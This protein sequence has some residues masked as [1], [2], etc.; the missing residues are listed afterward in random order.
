MQSLLKLLPSWVP[1]AVLGVLVAIIAGGAWMLRSALIEKG[2]A[3]VRAQD[4]EAIIEQNKKDQVLSASLIKELRTKVEYSNAAA[5]DTYKQID[6]RPVITSSNP[7]F[8][9]ASVGVCKILSQTCGP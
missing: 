2:E 9:D 6:S 3:T 8:H 1:F 4:A 5:I 7:V